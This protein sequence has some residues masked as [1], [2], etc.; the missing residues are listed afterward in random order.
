MKRCIG[1]LFIV[2]STVFAVSGQTTAFTYQGSLKDGV[3]AANGNYDFEFALFDAV[4]GG[5]Q[6]GST[7]PRNTVVV[8]NGIF[9]VSL[10]FGSAPFTGADR[11]LAISVRHAGGGAFTLLT[12]RQAVASTPY[13]IRSSS[14]AMADT[15]TTAS[16]AATAT[17]FTGSLS[18]DVTGTQGVTVVSSVG[19]VTAANVA[20]GANAA[21]AATTAS[22]ANAIVKRD[23]TGTILGLGI[24]RQTVSIDLPLM[25][26]GTGTTQS[27]TVTGATLG[28]SVSVSPTIALSDG[29]I[30]SWARVSATNT[31]EVR[32]N[33][34]YGPASDPSA[35][36]YYIRVIQ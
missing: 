15:A 12:P 22:I 35:Q 30:I 13:S 7:L 18:G 28:S 14:A 4:S 26:P 5:N 27:F 20:S 1:I 29:L 3:S 33:L 19:G 16:S 10:D 36:N 21:N 34:L 17:G 25:S 6:F 31:V 9:T 2:L 11:F 24:I 8:T 32:F 23:G